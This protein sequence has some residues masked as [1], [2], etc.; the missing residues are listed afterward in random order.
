MAVY[1]VSM[2]GEC[3]TTAPTPAPSVPE[4]ALAPPPP[5]TRRAPTEAP[6]RAR[7]LLSRFGTELIKV[8]L[9]CRFAC[10]PLG[11]ACR[12]CVASLSVIACADQRSLA[13]LVAWRW[14][15]LVVVD[16]CCF[17]RTAR[18]ITGLTAAGARRTSWSAGTSASKISSPSSLTVSRESIGF[19]DRH[20]R[21]V[22][23]ST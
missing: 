8:R 2:L 13:P 16:W 6:T 23:C 7:Y 9:G 21:R 12:A 18:S 19:L 15:S 11:W 3:E 17:G 20:T 4:P 14:S 10:S 5:P 22:L 1:S